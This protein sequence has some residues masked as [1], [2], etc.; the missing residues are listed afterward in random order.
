MASYCSLCALT[1][2][3]GL[4]LGSSQCRVHITQFLV[5]TVLVDFTWHLRWVPPEADAET[6]AQM[7]GV[8]FKAK[9]T[10]GGGE[11]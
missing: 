1:V 10:Q 7:Q 6:T 3:L 4:G 5:T 9:E 2:V 11:M 8:H